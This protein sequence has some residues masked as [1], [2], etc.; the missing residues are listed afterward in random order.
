LHIAVQDTGIGIAPERINAIFDPFTQADASMTR[1]FGGTGL[2]TTISRQLVALMGGKIWAESTPGVGTT[3]HVLLPLE[4]ARNGEAQSSERSD[5][6]LPP[7][8]VLAA[9]D[10]PQ[11]L[12]LLSLLLAKR[13][14][15]LDTAHDGAQAVQMTAEQRYDVLLMDMQMPQMDGLAATRAIRRA[16]SRTARRRCLSWR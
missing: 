3:F 6:P 11:N 12:E 7:L 5:Y 8:R 14:H 13:G 2:G 4:P 15:T 10:V 16:S 1:R 9:D